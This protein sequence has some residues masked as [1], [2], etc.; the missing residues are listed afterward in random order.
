M[1][2]KR[3]DQIIVD[4]GLAES[5]SRAQALVMAGLVFS[6]DR[7]LEKPGQQ[8]PEDAPVD[9]RGRDH[10]WVS[11]GGIK[12]A[13]AIDA[14]GL[15]PAAIEAAITP[16]TRAILPV[17]F[18]GR[19]CDMDA[20]MAI[21]HKHGLMVIDPKNV[22][23]TQ[24][25]PLKSAWFGL[26]W[27]PDGK[28]LYVQRQNRDQTRLDMLAVDPATGKARVLFTENAAERSW[29][30]L[31]ND[32]RFLKDGSLIWWSQRD[33]IGHGDGLQSVQ[34][35]AGSGR[36][37]VSL[38]RGRAWS[39]ASKRASNGRGRVSRS[40]QSSGTSPAFT[41][42][43]LPARVSTSARANE[44]GPPASGSPSPS[45]SIGR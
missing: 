9:V 40:R 15:D 27:A 1:G 5:R 33:G 25:T 8:L 34:T 31:S 17:H 23:I 6:G 29:I 39:S 38:Q 18:A 35:A 30:N 20:I 4:R 26:A 11:R 24:K 44:K 16:S 45:L 10:P 37:V 3:L 21:A 32:Y 2:K 13:H 42:P 28:T 22:E 14:F 7:K 12:L 43:S 41:S 19:P 36:S